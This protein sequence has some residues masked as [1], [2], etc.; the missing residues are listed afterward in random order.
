MHK[1][2]CGLGLSV[3]LGAIGAFALGACS[4]PPFVGVDQCAPGAPF[5]EPECIPDA[6]SDA[7]AGEE[8]SAPQSICAG[9]CAP[10][11]VGGTKPGLWHEPP[12]SLWI[13]PP[14]LVP[15]CCP[16]AKGCKD[17]SADVPNDKFRL[18]GELVAPPAA[19][20]PCE[21]GASEGTCTGLPESIEIR[22]GPCG[23]GGVTS[24]PFDGPAG[25]DG[26][27]S[28]EG[29]LPAGA[30]CPAGSNTPCA[31]TVRASPLPGPATESCPPTSAAP[32][33]TKETSWEIAALACHGNTREDDCNNPSAY[34]INDPGLAWLQCV[35]REGKHDDCPANYPWNFTFYPPTPIDDRGCEA[36]SCGAPVGS[37]CLATM[38][39]YDDGVC[40]QQAS[41]NA[42]S[43][44]EEQC[45][46]I[47]PPGRV[48]GAK[49]ITDLEYLPGTCEA[50]GGKPIGSV[51]ADKENA[52]S[53]CC[54]S[55]FD[56][57]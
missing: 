5:P 21:C 51:E 15:S 14:E 29:A 17:K 57:E 46:G 11:A 18:F 25:W 50:T 49:S 52:V 20:E 34:C 2:L 28:S 55:F 56:I 43:S 6:G 4:A 22:T 35:Y 16:G 19:C 9:R 33:F 40:G 44:F 38:R 3:L 42:L 48:L 27:C 13:G 1:Y 8:A 54:L 47:Q 53:F 24:L 32:T 39:I 31:H 41:V 37:G 10:V 23:Q 30:K 7:D 45:I 12:I 26:S 36:C